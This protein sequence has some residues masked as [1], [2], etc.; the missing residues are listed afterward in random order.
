MEVKRDILWRVYLSFLGIVVVCIIVL[1]KAF[2]IQEFEGKD[3]RRLADSLHTAIQDV[4]AERGTIYSEDGEML[5]T[6]LPKYDIYIDFMADGL[7]EK[8]GKRF[9]DNIDSLAISLANLFGDRKAAEYKKDLQR[10]YATKDRYYLLKKKIS[11][12]QFQ[13]LRTFPLVRLGRNKSGF[14]AD[15]VPQRLTPFGLLANRTIGLSREDSTKNVGL[16]KTYD[17]VLRGESGKRLIKYVA[18]GVRV[19]VEG[20]EIEPE[21]GKD[22]V[23]TIDVNIQDIAENALMDM[24]T[25]NEALQGSCIVME[26]Q[27]GKIKAI[28]NLGLH[29]GSYYEMDNYAIKTSEPGS[30]IKLITLMNA[31]EDKYVKITDNINIGGGTWDLDGRTIKDDHHSPEVVTIKEAFAH[32]SNVAMSKLAYQFYVKNPQQYYEHFEKL[33]LTKKSGLDLKEEFRPTVKNPANKKTWHFQTLASMGFGYDIMLSPIQ[34]LMVYNAVANNGKMMKP[35][36]VSRIEKDGQVLRTIQPQVVNEKICSD[37]TLRQLKECL[38]EVVISGT[39]KP[40]FQG[41]TY[42]VAGKTGTAKVNDGVYKYTDGVYQAAF[43]G[44]FPAENPKYS[45]IVVIKNKPHAANYYGGAVAGTVFREI[46]DKLYVLNLQQPNNLAAQKR[47][48]SFYRF[49]GMKN[50]V[51]QV[52]QPFNI[53]FNNS[54]NALWMSVVNDSIDNRMWRMNAIADAGKVVP[55]VKGYGLK[56][57]INLLENKG[58]KVVIKGRGKV[59]A[60]SILP[61]TTVNKGQQI[62]IQLA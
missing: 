35:Y 8:N 18:G 32:S 17:S 3:W 33:G 37:E 39:G 22:I 29:N 46:S 50:D 43:T 60:Q 48:S 9:K 38:E 58:L 21:N 56:D 1:W 6:S 25:K 30:T 16:E 28:A 13:Q 27:T 4:D 26:V 19:P 40:V 51:Q 45:C 57:A 11:F 52:S 5:S 62:I 47:D 55:D 54:G 49:V 44:Y 7:R 20:S 34:L 15:V 14:I 23:T 61:G 53:P 31:L 42:K 12:Q 2:Y 41:V 36:L 59:I 10:A 24:M